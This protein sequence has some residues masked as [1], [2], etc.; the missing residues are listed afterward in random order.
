MVYALFKGKIVP[1]EEA[2]ISV[3]T[4]ALNYGT[5]VFEG[6]RGYYNEEKQSIFI[7]KLRE[8]F[9]RLFN[10]A[11]IMMIDIHYTVDEL[12]EKTLEIAKL[13]NYKEDFYIRPLAY[14]SSEIIGVRLHNLESD[15]TIFTAPFG[16]YVDIESGIRVRT[17][18]WKRIDD[19][20]MPA[21]AKVCGAYVNSA[22]AKTDAMLDG[23]DEAIMLNLDG[24][25]AEGSAENLFMYKNGKMITP[26]IHENIL[27]GITRFA[28]IQLLQDE[29]GIEVVERSIDRTELY[30]ADE[31]FLCGTGAQVSPVIEIDRR[32]IGTGAVG[33]ITKKLQDIYFDIVRG[34]NQKY[35]GW[36]TEVK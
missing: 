35:S 28:L 21:R 8:H 31:M 32:K 19:T 34:N 27:E 2:K 1:L 24:H 6:I 12:C 4:H 25:V 13:N 17:S 33:G 15:L 3:V 11:K 22:F 18:S 5:G 30:L 23:Y 20:M 10:S 9:E 29:L 14:K 7:L 16:A 26:H 36:V